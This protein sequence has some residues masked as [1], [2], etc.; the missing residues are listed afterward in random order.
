MNR[1][2]VSYEHLVEKFV[3]WAETCPDIRGAVIVGSRARIDHPADEWSDLD[4]IVITTDPQRYLSTTDW[5]ERIGNSMLTFLEPTAVGDETERRVLFEDML[6]VDFAIM[7]FESIQ[8]ILQ[9]KMPPRIAAQTADTITRGT[10]VLLD[11]DGVLAQLRESILLAKDYSSCPPST[12]KFSEVIN[13]FLYHAVWTA[14]KLR[15]GELWTAKA[16]SDGYMK[17]LLL[18]IIEWHSHVTNGWKCDV[19]FNGR[20]LEEWTE[21]QVLDRLRNVFAHYDEVDVKQGLLATMD[22]FRRLATETAEKLG[23]RYPTK[24]DERVTEW[25]RNCLST[26]VSADRRGSPH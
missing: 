13:D 23:Y 26:T 5:I 17:R 19:W 11:K 21:P 9:N 25:V 2:S 4:I 10:R 12:E 14:K 8:H 16:C 24:T 18:R 22:M 6:D 1:I 20:F 15:R 7:P 3:E